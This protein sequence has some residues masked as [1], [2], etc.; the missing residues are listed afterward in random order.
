MIFKLKTD[1]TNVIKLFSDLL[2]TSCEP[3]GNVPKNPMSS[4]LMESELMRLPKLADRDLE[5]GLLA[6]IDYLVEIRSQ[7]GK[8]QVDSKPFGRNPKTLLS[9]IDTTLLKC[10]LETNDS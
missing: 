4:S 3:P 5:N 8:S 1:P 9:V 6:L 2:P 10:Y 7:V